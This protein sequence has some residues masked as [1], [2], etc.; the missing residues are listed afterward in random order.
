MW[1]LL[2]LL[3]N[4]QLSTGQNYIQVYIEDFSSKDRETLEAAYLLQAQLFK[5]QN[6]SPEALAS[7]DKALSINPD[8]K[9]ALKEKQL[10]LLLKP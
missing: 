6:K 5:L 8:F 9:P 4:T 10:I 1:L 2:A 3:H 7:I